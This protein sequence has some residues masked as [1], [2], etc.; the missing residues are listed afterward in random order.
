MTLVALEGNF[1]RDLLRKLP[2]NLR[3]V[4][5]NGPVYL[6]T[7]NTDCLLGGHYSRLAHVIVHSVLQ[8]GPGFPH[9][10]KAVYYYL[11]SGV[12]EAVQHLSVQ[13]LPLATQHVVK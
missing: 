10:P 12:D 9:L 11:V 7:S 2:I 8:E 5:Q 4:E 13:E 3:S 6:F 1:S